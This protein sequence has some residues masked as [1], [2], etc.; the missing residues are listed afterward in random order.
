MDF[1]TK[2]SDKM[3]KYYEAFKDKYS[4]VLAGEEDIEK[5]IEKKPMVESFFINYLAK[6]VLS[7][8]ELDFEKFIKQKGK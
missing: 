4:F 8:K 3:P 5:A 2:N 7:D 6:K 1:I